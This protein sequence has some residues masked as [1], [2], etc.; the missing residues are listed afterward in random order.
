MSQKKNSSVVSRL[1][2]AVTLAALIPFV[3]STAFAGP[4]P[5]TPGSM[6]WPTT[7]KTATTESA[8]TAESLPVL[9]Q[10]VLLLSTIF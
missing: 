7:G 10:F 3:G 6:T 4:G 2:L 5:S 9:Q 1:F 8:P